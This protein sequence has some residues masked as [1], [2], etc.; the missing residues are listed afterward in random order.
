MG[1]NIVGI[2]SSELLSIAI[3][4]VNQKYKSRAENGITSNLP[5]GYAAYFR[6]TVID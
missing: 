1:S 4:R 6:C 5:T 2:M 3:S